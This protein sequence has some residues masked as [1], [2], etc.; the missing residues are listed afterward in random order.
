ML[1]V[2]RVMLFTSIV[3]S[4][5]PV[6]IFT[7]VRA[8]TGRLEG[9]WST[10]GYYLRGARGK[11]CPD[12]STPEGGPTTSTTSS[13][14]A[15]SYLETPAGSSMSATRMP[16]GPKTTTTTNNKMERVCTGM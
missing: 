4:L 12:G 16:D 7:S 14:T 2:R 13:P 5:S 9:C 10:T 6:L 8:V 3:C 1:S 15:V 11:L